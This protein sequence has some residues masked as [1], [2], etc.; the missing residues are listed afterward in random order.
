MSDPSTL[1]ASIPTDGRAVVIGSEGTIGRAWTAFLRDT[2][3][4]VDV[5]GLSRRSSP[6]V[7]VTNEASIAHAAATVAGDGVPLR[8]LV[9]ASGLLHGTTPDGLDVQPEKSWR[10]LDAARMQHVMHVNAIGPALVLKHFLPQ[11]PRAGRSLIVVLSARAGS[12]EENR[13]GGW[14]GYR[15]AKAALNQIV[16]SAAAELGRK[17][18]EAVC[19]T[20]HPGHVESPLS[21]PF[22]AGG[23]ETLEPGTSVQRAWEALAQVDAGGT[24]RT[25]DVDGTPIAF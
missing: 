3:S 4:F 11:V 20:L 21:A 14:Y 22:G 18:K 17:S 6:P 19:V 2:G 8:C 12:I 24:G 10:T 15:A 9:V 1:T 13:I 7:D 5:V 16:R 23:H 25:Y